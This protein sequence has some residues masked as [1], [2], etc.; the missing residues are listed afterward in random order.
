[1][2][3]AEKRMKYRDRICL[4]RILVFGLALVTIPFLIY[5]A[6]TPQIGKSVQQSV[7][8]HPLPTSFHGLVSLK[9]AEFKKLQD[10]STRFIV[11]F[12]APGNSLNLDYLEEFNHLAESITADI[13]IR[14]GKLEGA[15]Y[16]YEPIVFGVVDCEVFGDLCN[17][18]YLHLYGYPTTIAFNFRHHG[19][20]MSIVVIV[21]HP[22]CSI[23]NNFQIKQ[24]GCVQ[25]GDP[26]L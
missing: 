4:N 12:Y 9:P 13:H 14:N 22:K 5:K 21:D 18:S 11:A 20:S 25:N 7:E 1:M 15:S 24:V 8:P 17:E 16:R 6:F 10:S 23:R 19:K 2:L 3:F 26:N